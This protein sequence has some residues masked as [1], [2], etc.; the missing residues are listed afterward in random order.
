[1][2]LLGEHPV[3][4]TAEAEVT[5]RLPDP[6]FAVASVETDSP[7]T[8]VSLAGKEADGLLRYRIRQRVTQ[9]GDFTGRITFTVRRPDGRS[10]QVA[11]RVNFY[12]EA[13]HPRD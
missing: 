8:M 6:R 4:S 11:T 13:R 9:Q 3:P 1:M 12:G 7:D 5:V 10:D 2:V